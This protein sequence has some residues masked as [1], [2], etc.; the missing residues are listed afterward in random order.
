MVLEVYTKDYKRENLIAIYGGVFDFDYQ[1]KDRTLRVT[2]QYETR[3]YP[4]VKMEFAV[5]GNF[6]VVCTEE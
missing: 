4:C 3:T 6:C 1:A 5:N 2:T